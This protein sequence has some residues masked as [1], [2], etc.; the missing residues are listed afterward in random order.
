MNKKAVLGW[1]GPKIL[2]ETLATKKA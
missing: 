2:H 1:D